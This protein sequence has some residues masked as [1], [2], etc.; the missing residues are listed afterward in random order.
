MTSPSYIARFA[1]SPTGYLHLGHVISMAFVF[2]IAELLSAKVLLRIEDHDGERCQERYVQ[3]ILDDMAWLGFIPHNWPSFMQGKASSNEYRQSS[4]LDLYDEI[5]SSLKA[6]QLAYPCSCSRKDLSA[7]SQEGSEDS[8]ERPY[9]GHCRI[10]PASASSPCGWRFIVP[11]ADIPF[12]DLVHGPLMQNPSKQCGDFLIKDRRGYYTYN[13]AVVVDDMRQGIN[14]IIRGND[15]LPCTGRQLALAQVLQPSP[16]QP[17]FLHHPLAYGPEGMKLS[18]RTLSAGIIQRR[19]SG[20][21][22]AVILGEA[23]HLAGLLPAP[24]PI[25][26]S[27]IAGVMRD[28]LAGQAI[29]LGSIKSH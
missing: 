3:A 29:H 4:C 28:H 11:D 7:A 8:G 5:L 14:L 6:K 12:S 20:D 9:S 16:K 17:L 26:A 23:L 1:P 15:I 22:P 21:L 24:L 27:D 18:K 10:H 13:F 19:L 25:K 2:G